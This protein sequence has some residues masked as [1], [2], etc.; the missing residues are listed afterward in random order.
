MLLLGPSLPVDILLTLNATEVMDTE[1][2]EHFAS[3]SYLSADGIRICSGSMRNLAC[4]HNP[5]EWVY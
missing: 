2:T 1:Q 5:C 3:K 4:F